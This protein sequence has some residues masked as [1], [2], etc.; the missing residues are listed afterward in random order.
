MRLHQIIK[1]DPDFTDFRTDEGLKAIWNYI[2]TNCS[3]YISENPGHL[4][5]PLYRGLSGNINPVSILSVN[6]N[7]LPKDTPLAIHKL[8]LDAFKTAGIKANRDNSIFCTGSYSQ[9]MDYST[10]SPHIIYP[11]G[12]FEFAYSND[13]TDLY[14]DM[15]K[16]FAKKLIV[17]DETAP[18]NFDSVVDWNN[19]IPE[20]LTSAYKFDLLRKYKDFNVVT[21]N[22][23]TLRDVFELYAIKDSY[24]RVRNLFYTS[25][26]EENIKDAIFNQGLKVIDIGLSDFIKQKYSTVDIEEAISSDVEILIHCQK[27][28]AISN[29]VFFNMLGVARENK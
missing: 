11:I 4:K 14:M 12:P 6:Q 29:E 19:L 3:D 13:I 10:F 16:L 1:E 17:F 5:R 24:E 20:R 2:R 15:E 7:R 18:L 25:L 23:K 22:Q 28:I 8:F 27:Y 26:T 9:A 21:M